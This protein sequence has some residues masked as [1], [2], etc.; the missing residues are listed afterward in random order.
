MVEVLN[1]KLAKVFTSTDKYNFEINFQVFNT[2]NSSSAVT[3][4]Y[5]AST[6]GTETTIES[7]LVFRIDGVFSF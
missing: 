7:A 5:L 2:L 1:M 3:T 4:S 6:F